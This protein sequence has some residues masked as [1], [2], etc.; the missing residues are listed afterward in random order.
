MVSL[1]PILQ[2]RSIF[3]QPVPVAILYLKGE[4]FFDLRLFLFL[5]QRCSWR[6]CLANLIFPRLPELRVDYLFKLGGQIGGDGEF[7][8]LG[9]NGSTHRAL[10]LERDGSFCA[11]LTENVLAG[12]TSWFDHNQHADGALWVN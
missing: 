11:G 12:Q 1:S 2:N 9:R 4:S 7:E 8:S 10:A 3:Y 5:L 6:D